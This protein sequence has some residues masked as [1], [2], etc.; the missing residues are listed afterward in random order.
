MRHGSRPPL[1]EPRYVS[2]PHLASLAPLGG[3]LENSIEAKTSKEYNILKREILEIMD[4]SWKRYL[5]SV[6][7]LQDWISLTAIGNR[8]P[9]TEFAETADRMFHDMRR[10]FA[11]AS[12]KRIILFIV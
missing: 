5:A 11:L 10:D 7:W 12:L 8:D 9:Y 3:P 2:G 4:K 6:S 1:G